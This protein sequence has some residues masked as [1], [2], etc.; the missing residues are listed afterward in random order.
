MKTEV[1]G[2]CMQ[3]FITTLITHKNIS[4]GLFF[5]LFFSQKIYIIFS[6]KGHHGNV[7]H[8]RKGRERSNCQKKSR[9]LLMNSSDDWWWWLC[10]THNHH[11]WWWPGHFMFDGSVGCSYALLLYCTALNLMVLALF[12][13]IRVNNATLLG[14]CDMSSLQCSGSLQKI[15][16]K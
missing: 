1:Y 14:L 13:E 9:W 12:N 8:R 3:A 7:L 15:P 11:H 6:V 4:M 5:F 10:C 16:V 2:S